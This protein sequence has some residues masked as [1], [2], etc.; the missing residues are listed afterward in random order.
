VLS[1]LDTYVMRVLSQYSQVS[2][3]L[4][5]IVTTV[6]GLPSFKLLPLGAVL[7]LLWFSRSPRSRAGV[8]DAILGMFA[9][10]VVSRLIQNLSPERVRPIYSGNPD[11]VLPI[12][13]VSH[14]P[15]DWSS[16]PSDHAAL[17]FALSTAIWRVSRSWG[18]FCYV[19]S[20]LIV[21]LPRIYTGAHYA[22][23]IMGGAA[24]GVLMIIAITHLLPTKSRL[25]P[26][27][28]AAEERYQALFY[29]SFFILSYQLVTMFEDV[30]LVGRGLHKLTNYL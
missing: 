9:A 15:P 18:A 13:T 22:S 6:F 17:T 14:V 29:A 30:R 28:V 1:A 5:K 23:D 26:W 12:G 19:W 3:I 24:I 10:L 8:L 16:F 2:E 7:W 25:M 4:N 21:C 20:T 27:I 11:F